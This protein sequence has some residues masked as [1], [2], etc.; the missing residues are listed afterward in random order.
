MA[1]SPTKSIH[2]NKNPG[3]KQGVFP[4]L[5][6]RFKRFDGFKQESSKFATL[7][8]GHAGKPKVLN[9]DLATLVKRGAF[10]TAL[11]AKGTI[12]TMDIAVWQALGL[13]FSI[14]AVCGSAFFFLSTDADFDY[15][16]LETVSNYLNMFIPFILGL[17]VSLTLQRWWELRTNGIGK[18]LDAAQNLVMI[19]VALLPGVEFQEFH[20]QVLKYAL[21]SV[22]LVVQ[23][24]RNKEN[25][26]ALGPKQECLLSAEE[27]EILIDIPI[28]PRPAV[29][30]SWICAVTTKVME[31]QGVPPGK[32]R[33]VLIEC[34]KAR[35]GISLIW[36]YLGTQLPFAY[37]H[38]VTFLVNLN[39]L[40]MAVKCGVIFAAS[41]RDMNW[42]H[43]G[44]QVVFIFVV[45]LLYQGLL[46][47][48]YIIHDPFGEDL[49]DFPIMAFQEYCNEACLVFSNYTHK[50]PALQTDYGPP[51]TA[52][53]LALRKGLGRIMANR[54]AEAEASKQKPPAP[55]PKDQQDGVD[56]T[57]GEVIESPLLDS[58]REQMRVKDEL[59]ACLQMQNSS[60]ESNVAVVSTRLRTIES[61]LG[62]LP[63]APMQPSSSQSWCS[64]PTIGADRETALSNAPNAI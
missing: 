23:T 62:R 14:A 53:M 11:S 36:T 46:S 31:E 60:L 26:E 22:S 55:M 5:D 9:Y 34:L 52:R 2:E 47:V 32:H 15:T 1:M 64:A 28:R 4:S 18:V 40:V 17:Y 51:P 59:V 38:L 44:S 10:L 41:L 58:L 13:Y 42:I 50:C 48:S 20:D 54:E 8:Y 35:D 45:P 37:V 6:V 61:Q 33:D 43:A 27:V 25:V 3:G 39:N 7:V 56:D 57:D 30:W 24:V 19:C 12:F 16:K 21:A 49:L 29:L 63:P